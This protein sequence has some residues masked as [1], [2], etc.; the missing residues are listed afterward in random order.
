M[1]RG[2][3]TIHDNYAMRRYKVYCSTRDAD[4]IAAQLPEHLRHFFRLRVGQ[5]LQL[6]P[7]PQNGI[8]PRAMARAIA[9][10]IEQ[11]PPAVIPATLTLTDVQRELILDGMLALPRPV[12]EQYLDRVTNYLL[13][14][15]SFNDTDVRLSVEKAT[16]AVT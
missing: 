4:R 5:R 1:R 3:P 11:L 14:L 2:G 10:A 16:M 12:H 13:A 7:N 6:T 15:P 8:A 9:S